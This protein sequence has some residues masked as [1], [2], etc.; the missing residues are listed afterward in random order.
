MRIQDVEK[1]ATLEILHLSSVV[2][3]PL[4]DRTGDRLGRVQDLIVR[5]G[6]SPHPPVVGLVV[7]IGGRDLFVPIRKISALEPGRVRFEGERV[8]LRRF[9]R[10]P[11]ELLLA[12]DLM[13]RHLINF[14]G[15]RLIRANEIELAR[16]NGTW[17]VVGVD[18]SSR[19]FIR[20]FLRGHL[21]REIV[22]NL[23]VD[24]ESIEPFVAHVPSA[25]LHIPY[26]K[27]A[28]LHPAQIADLVEAASHEEGEEIIEAVGHDR[29]L[30]ADVFEELDTEHQLEFIRNRSEADAA[31][32]LASMAPDDAADLIAEVDQERRLP[33]LNLLPEPQQR[34]V[35][36]LL[37]YNPETAGGLMSPDF[38][39][40]P[41]T[42][43][44]GDALAAV[45]E[46]TAPPETLNVVFA[47]DAQGNVVGSVSAVRM[48][49]ADPAAPLSSVVRPNPAHVHADWDF[50]ATVR[51]MSDFNLTV[52][53]VMDA[54]HQKMVGVVTVD[55]VLEILMPHG[56]RRD[57]GVTAAED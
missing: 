48:I 45:H 34:K 20:R 21:G 31:Q 26:R 47:T 50:G 1:A 36:A 43:C 9:E 53:P 18:P 46:S 57:F 3:R 25:R 22:P 28:R 40:L 7:S 44:V 30:E 41:E 42:A 54:D 37:S 19:P 55:D 27:L 38:L 14:V 33:M 6:G 10:R 32:L 2:R 23:I 4:V 39:C 24:W 16:V 49:Q 11:G 52:A 56:W 29:E 8:D 51:K 17:E 12:R 5:V 35:R 15:G 13:T